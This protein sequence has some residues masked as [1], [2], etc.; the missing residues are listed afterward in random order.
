MLIARW[1]AHDP[2]QHSVSGARVLQAQREPSSRGNAFHSVADTFDF[3]SRAKVKADTACELSNIPN[4]FGLDD[5]P[6]L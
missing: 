4:S 2:S 1:I 3:K 6:H 5:Y